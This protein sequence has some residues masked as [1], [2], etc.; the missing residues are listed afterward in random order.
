MDLPRQN[1]VIAS[2]TSFVQH[3]PASVSFMRALAI[4][5]IIGMIVAVG[6]IALA[7][8]FGVAAV[9][10]RA[11]VEQWKRD[12]PLDATVDASK[13][14][15]WK[16]P[17]TQTCAQSAGVRLHLAA[18]VDGHP[19]LLANEF[20]DDLSG[21]I[22][23]KDANDQ[24]VESVRFHGKR[25][26][27]Y[28]GIAHLLL[29]DGQLPEGNYTATIR[30]DAGAM[31]PSGSRLRLYGDYY[32]S[33]LEVVPYVEGA[34]A[35]VAG[36]IAVAVLWLIAPQT[37]RVRHWSDIFTYDLRPTGLPEP[38]A[39]EESRIGSSDSRR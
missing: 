39:F 5:R 37:W 25:S 16:V 31:L 24:P 7:I 1:A 33:T 9:Q 14:G 13:P 10:M 2:N 15:E 19:F 8:S 11:K 34:M 30:I 20:L 18:D 32:L 17:Y 22:V 28:Q 35:G 3:H 6:G 29:F 36:L 12:R 27:T 21:T 38:P 23:I 26:Q 4:G